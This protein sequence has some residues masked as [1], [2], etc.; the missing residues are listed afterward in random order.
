MR[1]ARLLVSGW[2]GLT[3]IHSLALGGGGVY[4][5][6]L[7]GV[8]GK[9]VSLAQYKGKITLLVNIATRGEYAT[10]LAALQALNER[11]GPQGLVVLAVPSSNFADLTPG[12]NA[13]IESFCRTAY[14]ATFPVLGKVS[15]R[16]DDQVA[17]YRYLTEDA[18]TEFKGDIHWAFTKFLI[19]RDGTVLF[20]FEPGITP[21]DPTL[22]L[23]VEQVLSGKLPKKKAEPDKSTTRTAVVAKFS[24]AT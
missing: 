5:Y 16:G 4:D 8:D 17:L 10:Q 24:T 9:S 2:F 20:R 11:Y 19:G 18:G 12:T 14:K 23:A 1:I 7:P 6:T 21:G 3:A 15:V 22:V 13:E